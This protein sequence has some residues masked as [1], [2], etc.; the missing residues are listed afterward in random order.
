LSKRRTEVVDVFPNHE[1]MIRLAG[2]VL[3]EAHDEWQV[4]ERHRLSKGSM[5]LLAAQAS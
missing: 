4:G 2:A 5:V 3:A 1:A